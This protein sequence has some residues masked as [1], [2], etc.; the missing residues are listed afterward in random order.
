MRKVLDQASMGFV[1]SQATHIETMV[2]EQ[3]I[4][5]VDYP[6]IVPVKTDIDPGAD[7]ITT[8]VRMLPKGKMRPLA[9]MASDSGFVNQD[10]TRVTSTFVEFGE[11]Y[12]WS[13]NDIERA[14]LINRPLESDT[15]RS[16]VEVIEFGIEDIVM[17]GSADF[18]WKGLLKT[19][20]DQHQTGTLTRAVS[21]NWTSATTEAIMEDILEGYTQVTTTTQ[22]MIKPDTLLIPRSRERVFLR[23]LSNQHG[24]TSDSLMEFLRRNNPYAADSGGGQMMI[25]TVNRLPNDVAVLMSSREDVVRLLMPRPL[26]FT[27]P[28]QEGWNQV[29][30]GRVKLGGLQFLRPHGILYFTG[31]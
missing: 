22:G 12:G 30:Y 23:A 26:E 17:N 1:E 13:M 5:Q 11:N 29:W 15:V 27:G 3:V 31:V 9:N 14:R 28:Q 25:K 21:N 24:I 16:A 20:G 10:Y 8:D 18:G 6:M 7:S 19:S 2:R 4:A